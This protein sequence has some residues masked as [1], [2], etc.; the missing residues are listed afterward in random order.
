MR[1]GRGG[2]GRG[3]KKKE[4]M[5]RWKKNVKPKY[6]IKNKKKGKFY[7]YI[8]DSEEDD[9]EIFSET[10]SLRGQVKNRSSSGSRK[11][12]QPVRT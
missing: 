4:E 12:G 3:S 10:K 7:K 5:K 1:M 6:N 8:Y 9:D 11:M 2:G